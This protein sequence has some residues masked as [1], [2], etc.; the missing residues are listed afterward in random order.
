MVGNS[1]QADLLH[2]VFGCDDLSLPI[3]NA[4]SAL[5]H[6]EHLP[7]LNFAGLIVRLSSLPVIF[8]VSK[9]SFSS[10]TVISARWSA[11]CGLIYYHKSLD[12]DFFSFKSLT[13]LQPL[14]HDRTVAS[15]T[16]KLDSGILNALNPVSSPSL[17]L[18]YPS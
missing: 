5:I 15:N 10:E 14:L 9:S 6:T 13:G 4:F 7:N 12:Q 3:W 1:C 18:K 8:Q 17:A 16:K 11:T 2:G